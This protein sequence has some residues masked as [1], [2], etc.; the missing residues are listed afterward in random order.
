[1]A[2]SISWRIGHLNRLLV[3]YFKRFGHVVLRSQRND[4]VMLWKW[5]LKCLQYYSHENSYNQQDVVHD[6]VD[7]GFY[8]LKENNINNIFS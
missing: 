7:R 8:F 1:M 2:N 5:K 6:V 4:S 3:N